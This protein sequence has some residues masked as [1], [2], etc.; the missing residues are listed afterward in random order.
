MQTYFLYHPYRGNQ[1]IKLCKWNTMVNRRESPHATHG[2]HILWCSPGITLPPFLFQTTK[3]PGF[4]GAKSLSTGTAIISISD[5]CQLYLLG[6]GSAQTYSLGTIGGCSAWHMLSPHLCGPVYY[7]HVT[8]KLELS[9]W[10]ISP[11]INVRYLHHLALLY[12][13]IHHASH[14]IPLLYIFIV[15]LAFLL[16][17]QSLNDPLIFSNCY[18][19]TP[20]NIVI[21]MC[22]I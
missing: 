3:L 10:P 14:S 5:L 15:C 17:I 12:S 21:Y 6:A 22:Y 4:P 20:F 13:T 2:C 8:F 18:I 1:S 16:I 19:F 7:T 11:H 9:D